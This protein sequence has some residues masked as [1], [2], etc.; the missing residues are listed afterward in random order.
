MQLIPSDLSDK[1]CM[2]NMH[3]HDVATE[4]IDKRRFTLGFNQPCKISNTKL[5][6]L[7]P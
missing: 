4:P 5:R 1:Q 2:S 7:E 6:A 3:I